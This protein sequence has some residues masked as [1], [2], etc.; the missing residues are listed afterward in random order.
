MNLKYIL[1]LS[2]NHIYLEDTLDIS[3]STELKIT[4]K[5]RSL[6]QSI[7]TWCG[8]TSSLGFVLSL[9][10]AALLILMYIEFTNHDSNLRE[11]EIIGLGLLAIAIA[12]MILFSKFLWDY[13]TNFKRSIRK[14]SEILLEKAMSGLRNAII[15]I[16]IVWMLGTAF[17]VFMFSVLIYFANFNN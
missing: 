16:S 8:I 2:L 6:M 12:I 11:D 1:Y 7:G 15:M 5:V 9:G 14:D 4:A 3:E 17:I 10:G 13:R